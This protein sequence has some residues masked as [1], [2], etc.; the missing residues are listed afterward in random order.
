[1][2][3]DT[4]VVNN[5]IS[6]E[7]VKEIDPSRIVISP[8][9]GHPTKD[10]GNCIQIIRELGSKIPILG[11]CLGHQAIV[12]AFGGKVIRGYYPIH[13]KASAVYHDG[14]GIFKNI[15]NPF[16]MGCYHSLVAD[17]S[18]LPDCL[19]VSAKFENGAIAGIRH[20]KYP[21]E[22]TQGH[23]ESY[24]T[25]ATIGRQILKNFLAL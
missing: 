8:G 15:P 22:G 18:T 21:I 19:E 5:T 17:P 16:L 9:P 20:K 11:V 13:G 25:N 6:V 10:T 12:E 4:L 1:M 23:P 14:K 24:L 2:D 3:P 7:E